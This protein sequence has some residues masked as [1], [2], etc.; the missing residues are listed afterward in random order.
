MKTK[1][2]AIELRQMAGFYTAKEAADQLGMSRWTFYNQLRSERWP[3]P[4]IRLIRGRRC[5]YT[6]TEVEELRKHLRPE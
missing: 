3:R 5:Y 2:G 1:I 6:K 4:T